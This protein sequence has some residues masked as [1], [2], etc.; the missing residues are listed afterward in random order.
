MIFDPVD[1]FDDSA[2][3]RADIRLLGDLLGQTLVK[4]G[5][6][7][8][9]K[10]VYRQVNET[11]VGSGENNVWTAATRLTAA[12]VLGEV[13][14][15]ED[16]LSCIEVFS[17]SPEERNSIRGGLQQIIAKT[18]VGDPISRKLAENNWL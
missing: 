17:P 4:L 1:L 8:Q 14:L 13:P 12:I 3:L 2:A 7:E 15:V 18:G 10:E 11:L 5:E 6:I 16:A 9:A